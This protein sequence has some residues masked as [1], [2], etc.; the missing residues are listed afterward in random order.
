ME[1]SQTTGMPV[2]QPD[3]NSKKYWII[4]GIIVLLAIGSFYLFS[5]KGTTPPQGITIGDQNSLS[6]GD[7]DPDAVAV[8]ISKAS[9]LKSGF[10]VIQEN[11]SSAPGKVLATSDLFSPGSYTNKTII[12]NM[13]AGANYFGTLYG[14]D[15]NGLF[16]AVNDKPLTDPDGNIVRVPFKVRQSSTSE[17]IK[18]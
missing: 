9:F 8:L 1:Q 10:I 12:M 2:S 11:I 4:G 3:G 18:G 5:N 7:Q 17:D 16:D 6:I 15:G 14:D 13:T